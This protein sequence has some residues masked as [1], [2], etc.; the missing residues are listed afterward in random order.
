MLLDDGT[1]HISSAV[2]LI[3]DFRPGAAGPRA[4]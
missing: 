2:V 4:L 1:E 3:D